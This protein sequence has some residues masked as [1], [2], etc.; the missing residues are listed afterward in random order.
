MEYLKGKKKLPKID[1]LN[2][3]YLLNYLNVFLKTLLERKLC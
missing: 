1:N 2:T 3:V